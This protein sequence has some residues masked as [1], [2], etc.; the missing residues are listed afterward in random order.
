MLETRRVLHEKAELRFEETE[1]LAHIIYELLYARVRSVDR[2]FQPLEI[3]N[4]KGG[5]WADFT[6][7]PGVERLLFRADVDAL[8]IQEATGLPFAS[9]NP[10]KMHACGHDV[11]SAMLLGAIQ[12]IAMGMVTPK[13][14]LR[15]VFQRAEENPVTESGGAMLV[16][17]GVLEGVSRVFGLHVWATGKPGVFYYREGAFLGNSGRM[18]IMITTSGGHVAQPHKGVNALRVAHAVM[19]GLESFS[20]QT[21]GPI[22]PVS[23]EPAILKS[24]TASNVMPATA[25]LWYGVRTLLPAKD[26]EEY[27]KKLEKQVQHIVAG[28]DGAKV[29]CE[30]ILGHPALH[31]TPEDVRVISNLLGRNGQQTEEHPPVL[32]G[33]DFAHYL[34]NRPGAYFMLGAHQDGCGDHHMPTFNP[35]ESVFWKGVLYWLSLATL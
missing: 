20:V 8:P 21:L 34:L 19:S 35:D 33:E 12:A 18:K 6:V 23:L 10:G 22:E 7:D 9:K 17:E 16:R 24:G 1:T 4:A 25:E 3:N 2:G 29:E 28:F 14:N 5:I 15:F 13:Y 32:G 31:N 30:K 26:H 27:L 11:H